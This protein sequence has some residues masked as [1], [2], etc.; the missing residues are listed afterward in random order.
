MEMM[1]RLWYVWSWR[2]RYWWLDTGAGKQA[3]IIVWC[4]AT[5][6]T[7]LHLV[8]LVVVGIL[9]PL[10]PDQPAKAFSWWVAALVIG[11]ALAAVSFFMRPKIEAPKPMKSTAPNTEDGLAVRDVFG[12]VWI[13][14]QFVLAWK[15]MGTQKIKK[16]GGKK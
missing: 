12:T 3:R 6:G 2:L 10:A 9:H 7:V 8:R 4:L 13:D 11:I 15:G 16:K 5:L 1:R 14:D